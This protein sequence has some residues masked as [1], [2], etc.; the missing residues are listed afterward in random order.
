MR[1]FIALLVTVSSLAFA[2]S[3]QPKQQP[4]PRVQNVTFGDHDIDGERE[5]PSHTYVNVKRKAKFDSLIK[6]RGNF[7]DKLASSVDAL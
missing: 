1:T 5:L 3:E 2:Q 6:M 7:N 4:K